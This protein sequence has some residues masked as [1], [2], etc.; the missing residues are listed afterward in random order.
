M[1]KNSQ[2]KI[3]QGRRKTKKRKEKYISQNKI[4]INVNVLV[5]T[6]HMN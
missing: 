4:V 2:L 1:R 5:I 6:V 3:R